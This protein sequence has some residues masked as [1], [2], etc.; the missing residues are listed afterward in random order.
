MLD[1]GNFHSSSSLLIISIARVRK[2]RLVGRGAM[3]D[4]R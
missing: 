3:N 4:Q 1:G 2:R